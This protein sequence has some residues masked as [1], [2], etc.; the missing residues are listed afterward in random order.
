MRGWFN[1]AM[2]IKIGPVLLGVIQPTGIYANIDHISAVKTETYLPHP[3]FE[4]EG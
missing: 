3:H 2:A 4:G 1:M